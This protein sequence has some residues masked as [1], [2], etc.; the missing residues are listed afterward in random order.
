MSGKPNS[1]NRKRGGYHHGDLRAALLTAARGEVEQAG[2]ERLS[3]RGL[4]HRLGVSQPAPFRHFPDREA[5]LTALA[6]EGFR[7]LAG[8]LRAARG[9][10]ATER[11]AVM[12]DAYLAFAREQAGLYRLMFGTRLLHHAEPGG[13]LARVAEESFDLL[14][15]AVSALV[16][17]ADVDGV[18]VSIWSTLHGAAMLKELNLLHAEKASAAEVTRRTLAAHLQFTSGNGL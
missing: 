11:L 3:L 9:Y 16:P 15:Q 7:E 14:R 6:S 8:R 5:L 2:P 12:A 13:E 4:A 17:P 1:S 10:D 18:A